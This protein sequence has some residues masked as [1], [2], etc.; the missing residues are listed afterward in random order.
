MPSD[1]L[2][3]KGKPVMIT[4]IVDSYHAHYL[5]TRRSVT[6]ELMFINRNPIRR[7][8]RRKNTIETL[9]YGSVPEVMKIAM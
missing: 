5:E 4:N 2:D 7:Y 3:T 6:E 8:R 1:M 9:T